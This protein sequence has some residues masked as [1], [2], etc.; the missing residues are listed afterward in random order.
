MRTAASHGRQSLTRKGLR[1][2][3]T[4]DTP[5]CADLQPA[6]RRCA[7]CAGCA[8][9]QAGV[10]GR[11]G[12]TH[13]CRR[14]SNDLV[15]QQAKSPQLVEPA[16]DTDPFKGWADIETRQPSRSGFGTQRSAVAGI[17]PS[18]YICFD[19]REGRFLVSIYVN[20][21]HCCMMPM[22]FR[23]FSPNRSSATR[24]RGERRRVLFKVWVRGSG[25]GVAPCRQRTRPRPPLQAKAQD[26]C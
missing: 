8:G 11:G 24:G 1:V 25:C 15:G 26:R 5:C 2:G 21:Y 6:R 20:A 7:G 13:T 17:R 22:Y 14:I 18:K 4:S 9:L 23:I 16:S 19:S 3:L 12:G 10:P